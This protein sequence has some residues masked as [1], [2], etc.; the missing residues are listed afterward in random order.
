V[1]RFGRG[2][3]GER[4]AHA[5]RAVQQ[6]DDAPALAADDVVVDVAL[7]LDDEAKVVLA[8]LLHDELVEGVRAE[9]DGL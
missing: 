9:F 8:L 6:E 3:G 2:L 7:V 1:Q 5:G 4:L